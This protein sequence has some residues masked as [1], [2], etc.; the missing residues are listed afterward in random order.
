LSSHQAFPLD[1]F[2]FEP[3]INFLPKKAKM[4]NPEFYPFPES[5]H[6]EWLE[7]IKKDLKGKVDES[8]LKS[9]LWDE[10][11][12]APTY[13]FEQRQR[14][15]NPMRFNSES[16]LPGL[17]PRIWS[18][19]VS[20]RTGDEKTTNAEIL[21]VLQLGAEGL[22]LHLNGTEDLN[23][24]LKGVFTAYIPLYFL[25]LGEARPVLIQV[26]N[27]V[28]SRQLTPEM[29]HG[30]ILW[31]PTGEL[32]K[33]K[34]DLKEQ[35][36]LAAGLISDYKSFPDFHP[37]TIDF[38]RYSNAGGTGIQELTFGLGELI[39]ILDL[40]IQQGI[41]A[42]QAVGKIAFHT[43]IGENHF[44]EIAKMKTIRS[45]LMDL[46][47][48]L[49]GNLGS[50]AIHLLASTSDWSKSSLDPNTS[51]IRQTYE[52][53]AAV[54]GGCNS[55]WVKAIL[56][57]STDV[58]SKRISRNVSTILSEESFLNKVLDP[59]A[60][61]Y[62]LETLQKE[63][64]DLVLKQLEILENDGGWTA[65]F[66]N[67]TIHTQI[68]KTATKTQRAVLEKRKILVGVNSYELKN[69]ESLKQSPSNTAYEDY[70]L[71]P[72][73]ASYLVETEKSNQL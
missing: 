71:R 23:L 63:I 29:L 40:F 11:Q 20:P 34:T 65:N 36:S 18:N 27:W 68:K 19:V 25:P 66:M 44:P 32:F 31:S 46:I 43:A 8:T 72:S 50:E 41:S 33:G 24:I 58:L 60:G 73:R 35:I 3:R 13:S 28:E 2:I 56:G 1:F 53:M 26:K 57:Q 45:L 15:P 48:N 37:I 4:P 17:P 54:M 51:L 7:Q 12:I 9:V 30:A 55:L 39:E 16:K 21:E 22:V 62:Y 59:G 42:D 49:G 14:N 64:T 38:A 10:I 5:S 6:A 67:R 52:A 69:E 70:E 47:S 61:S